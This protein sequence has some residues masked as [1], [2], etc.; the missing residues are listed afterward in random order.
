MP[1]L[2]PDLFL[3]PDTIVRLGVPPNRVEILTSISG[4]AFDAGWPARVD[5]PWRG[6]PVHVLS[7]ADLKANKAASGRAKDRADLD[8][9]P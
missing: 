8:E 6:V 4:I 3:T 2:T 5:A 7:L 9:L 1:G